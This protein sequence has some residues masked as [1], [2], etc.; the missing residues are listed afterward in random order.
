M[1]FEKSLAV[2][3]GA[4]V[5][6][7]FLMA[8]L[9][10]LMLYGFKAKKDLR[11]LYASTIMFLSYFI[12][13]HFYSLFASHEIYKTWFLYDL[14]TLL[15]II[16]VLFFRKPKLSPGV[17]YVF[18]GLIFNSVMFLLMHYDRV[19][20]GNDEAW[21]FWSFYS[22]G[23]NLCDLTMI[24]VLIVDRDI[25]GLITVFEKAKLQASR[26][27]KHDVINNLTALKA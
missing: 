6:W 22:I 12:S 20:I 23:V 3:M 4:F 21:W 5:V 1:Y 26:A 11:L 16:P 18:I 13:D 2:F 7:G 8:M 15:L 24:A 27:L 14:V 10:N 25:L 17:V 19:V 9:F